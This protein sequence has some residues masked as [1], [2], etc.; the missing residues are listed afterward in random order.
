MRHILD[1]VQVVD[2]SQVLA[3]PTLT[4]FMVELGAEVIKIELPPAGDS[5]RALPHHHPDTG[6]SAYYVQQNRGKR[7]I[8]LDPRVPE[9]ADAVRQLV[10]EADVVVESFSPGTIDRL[11]FGWDTVHELNPSAVMVSI[12]AFGQ[13]GPLA[14]KPGYDNIAQAY[15]GIMS[16]IGEPDKP[17]PIVAA[18]IGDVMTGVHGF[19]AVMAA[20][21]HRERTGEGQHVEVSLLDSY[22]GCHEINVQ[23]H[24]ISGGDIEPT[25]P[26][27][28]HFAVCPFGVF[29]VGDPA[30][31]GGSV[32]ICLVSPDQWGRLCGLMGRADMVDDPRYVDNTVRCEHQ[33]EVN[34][35][36][37]SWLATIP[38][39]DA[40]IETLESQRIPCAPV[41]SVAEMVAHPHMRQR[42]T[43]R[44]VSDRAIGEFDVPGFP[45]RFSAFPE[46]LDLE[47]PF[48]GE[49]NAEVLLERCGVDQ[50]TFDRLV[51][52][53]SIDSEPV[54]RVPD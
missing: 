38:S 14:R 27:S 15:S 17:P 3:G 40:A 41:L 25:R 6:R 34:E 51:A 7:S 10:A 13:E 18:A 42:G 52:D 2:F 20:L 11:G 31:G 37:T 33:A 48:L 5:S 46:P 53:G 30:N 26:G 19:G 49:H 24:S 43:I 28:H 23:A 22:V 39:A 4:R 12:S 29:P 44:T 36:I 8:C 50:A 21:F 45:L 32:V 54:V 9:A 47:A 16:M 35:A 1:G